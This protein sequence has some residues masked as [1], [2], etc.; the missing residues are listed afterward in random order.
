MYKSDAL[1]DRVGP[2]TFSAPSTYDDLQT[3]TY[4]KAA[5]ETRPAGFF[6]SGPT[7]GQSSS[8]LLRTCDHMYTQKQPSGMSAPSRRQRGLVIG[9]NRQ[10]IATEI[11]SHPQPAISHSPLPQHNCPL[12]TRHNTASP[13]PLPS[14]PYLPTRID[15]CF[16]CT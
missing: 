4:I 15:P 10:I 2:A 8:L 5:E 9:N 16:Q 13:T 3:L 7:T 12:G 1:I 14:P 6:F 11:L